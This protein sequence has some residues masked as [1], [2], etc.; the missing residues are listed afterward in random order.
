M[1][2][3][4]KDEKTDTRGIGSIANQR[5]RGIEREGKMNL[6]AQGR[7]GK[8]F[9]PTFDLGRICTMYTHTHHECQ[10]RLSSSTR[11]S[12]RIENI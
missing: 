2:I 11:Q 1:F 8:W 10:Q 3:S 9:E 6:C 7:N 5:P 4:N 12:K